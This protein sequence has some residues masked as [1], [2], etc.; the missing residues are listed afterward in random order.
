MSIARVSGVARVS[1]LILFAVACGGEP[2]GLKEVVRIDAPHWSP[3]VEAGESTATLSESGRAREVLL[4]GTATGR[5]RDGWREWSLREGPGGASLGRLALATDDAALLHHLASRDRELGFGFESNRLV[6][7]SLRDGERLGLWLDGAATDANRSAAAL[8]PMEAARLVAL[9]QALGAWRAVANDRYRV[10]SGGSVRLPL[11]VPKPLRDWRALRQR[12]LE[13]PL[14]AALGKQ[15]ATR[16]GFRSNRDRAL[17]QFA[18][19][20]PQLAQA[21]DRF[22]EA[23][24]AAERSDAILQL[25]TNLR[26]SAAVYAGYLDSVWA[27]LVL[28]VVTPDSARVRILL[29][30]VVDVQI[31]AVLAALPGKVIVTESAALAGLRMIPAGDTATADGPVR[32]HLG[33]ERVEFRLGLSVAPRAPAT[34]TFE[35]VEFVFTLS[36]LE[37]LG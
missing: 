14:P 19:R 15:F 4:S 12:S 2:G 3:E 5:A 6:R 35:S 29:H 21:V 20:L 16:E 7:L 26:E 8:E 1:W 13:F 33:K 24:P 28:Q 27:E 10:T 18:K 23:L 37:A 22:V 36:G 30:S 31:D 25:A 32:A 9:A 34:S 11:F 17:A